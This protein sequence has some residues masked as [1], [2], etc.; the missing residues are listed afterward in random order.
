[1]SPFDLK[2]LD[3][4]QR[5]AFESWQRELAL[6]ECECNGMPVTEQEEPQS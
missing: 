3:D 2:Q 5:R 6:M 4:A 1:M